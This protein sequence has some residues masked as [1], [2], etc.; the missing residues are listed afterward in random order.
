[1]PTFDKEVLNTIEKIIGIPF[2]NDFYDEGEVCFANNDAI[3]A[4]FR[5]AFNV[6]DVI[7]YIN[8]IIHKSERIE[9]S[10][11]LEVVLVQIPYPTDSSFFWEQVAT[12][13]KLLK[14]DL[15]KQ[16]VTKNYFEIKWF[17]K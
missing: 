7:D 4:D 17:S 12:G 5:Q 13:K 11:F 16:N 15:L 8:A 3:R 1:M 2:I 6:F 9:N 14:S 10:I